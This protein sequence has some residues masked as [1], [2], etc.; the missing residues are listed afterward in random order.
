MIKMKLTRIKEKNDN[1]ESIEIIES[2]KEV[3]NEIDNGIINEKES[4]KNKEEI[5]KKMLK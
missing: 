2:H 1:I 4:N 3:N 5:K